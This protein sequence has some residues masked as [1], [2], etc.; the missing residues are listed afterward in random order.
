ML[1][2]TVKTEGMWI[3]MGSYRWFTG[4]SVRQKNY[5]RH[6]QSHQMRYPFLEVFQWYLQHDFQTDQLHNLMM[7]HKTALLLAALVICHVLGSSKASKTFNEK[8][9]SPFAYQQW[10]NFCRWPKR[11]KHWISK[12][13][14]IIKV[15]N[16]V[17]SLAQLTCKRPPVILLLYI[18][19]KTFKIMYLLKQVL[20][21]LSLW[22]DQASI[23]NNTF[24][25]YMV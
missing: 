5:A 13:Q 10:W 1:S 23:K 19:A 16:G 25:N 18:K 7:M 21:E 6:L 17:G 15:T 20:K 14:I 3:H 22:L 11:L 12:L 24:L 9:Q 8:I 4:Q 2:L